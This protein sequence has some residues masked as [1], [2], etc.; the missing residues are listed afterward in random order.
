MQQRSTRMSLQRISKMMGMS[1][2]FTTD[3]RKQ[4]PRQAQRQWPNRYAPTEGLILVALIAHEQERRPSRRMW[5]SIH[6]P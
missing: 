5:L 4:Q 2:I 3:Q 6:L 1:K